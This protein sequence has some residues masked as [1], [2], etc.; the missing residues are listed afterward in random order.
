ML[1]IKVP[2]DKD[3]KNES[4]LFYLPSNQNA[5]DKSIKELESGE[6]VVKTIDELK[7]MNWISDKMN[8]RL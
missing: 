8:L 2:I 4:D 1:P 3:L 5:I 7:S 6:V